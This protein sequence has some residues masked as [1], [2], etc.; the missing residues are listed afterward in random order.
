ME[1]KKGLSIRNIFLIPTFLWCKAESPSGNLAT[2]KFQGWSSLLQMGNPLHTATRLLSH[3]CLSLNSVTYLNLKH[4][5][6]IQYDQLNITEHNHPVLRSPA[7]RSNPLPTEHESGECFSKQHWP[8]QQQRNGNWTWLAF[9]TRVHQ[10][11]C[12]PDQHLEPVCNKKHCDPDRHLK[13]VCIKDTVKRRFVQ[14]RK[15]HIW[16]IIFLVSRRSENINSFF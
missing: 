5:G 7:T 8:K 4:L 12:E 13:P 10:R 6:F 3:Y 9:R 1:G 11:H 16:K 2:E 15:K 14:W